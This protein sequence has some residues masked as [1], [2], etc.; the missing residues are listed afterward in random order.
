MFC[1]RLLALFVVAALLLFA[2]ASF[3]PSLDLSSLTPDPA[4]S[5]AAE[6][7]IHRLLPEEQAGKIE[8]KVDRRM[9]EENEGKD[10]AKIISDKEMVK[11]W[12]SS[13]ATAAWAVGEYL[14]RECGCHISWDFRQ[15]ETIP[16]EWPETN[17]TLMANDKVRFYQV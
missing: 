2:S 16:E 5:A 9:S 7:L 1:R 8:I 6:R 17:L 13:G 4:Q 3:S 15:L 10:I 12:G 11:V 14:K